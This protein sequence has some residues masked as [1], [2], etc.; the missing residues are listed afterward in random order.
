MS[1]WNITVI[2]Q[3]PTNPTTIEDTR[4][5]IPNSDLKKGAYWIERAKALEQILEETNKIVDS[6]NYRIANVFQKIIE[7]YESRDTTYQ[8]ILETYRKELDNLIK[9][10]D[11][12]ADA[13][14]KLDKL[15]RRQKRKTIVAIAGTA[16]IVG[17]I[18]ILAK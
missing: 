17:G 7:E 12:A 8:A 11:N 13:A 14:K 16:I 4:T 2:S 15:L 9:Q 10:R 18:F 1:C 6:L 3:T 5:W